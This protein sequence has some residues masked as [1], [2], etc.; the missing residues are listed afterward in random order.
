MYGLE[1]CYY[2]AAPSVSFLQGIKVHIS[3]I[4]HKHQMFLILT[5]FSDLSSLA[6]SN[7]FKVSNWHL[8]MVFEKY[9]HS[10]SL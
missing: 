10:T 7:Q 6:F 8:L 9:L 5:N 2:R 3:F 1:R 4:Q